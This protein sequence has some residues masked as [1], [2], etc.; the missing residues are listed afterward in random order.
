MRGIVVA[1]I[2]KVKASFVNCASKVVNARWSASAMD[3]FRVVSR[4]KQLPLGGTLIGCAKRLRAL[5]Y[6]YFLVNYW[7]RPKPSN[8]S[9]VQCQIWRDA[10]AQRSTLKADF[11]WGVTDTSATKAPLTAQYQA[12]VTMVRAQLRADT[13]AMDIGAFDGNWTKELVAARQIIAVDC[14]P[15]AEV[16]VRQRLQTV[17]FQGE[18]HF[19][20]TAGDEL[21]GIA[22]ASVDVVVSIDSLVRLEKPKFRRFLQ[23]IHRVLRPQG[24]A[25]I[26]VGSMRST[27]SLLKNF[28]CYWDAELRRYTA[29]FQST[30]IHRHLLPHGVILECVK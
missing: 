25:L 3:T 14:F 1:S 5:R 11:L 7:L 10:L 26:H 18:Y 28:V 19:Y 6:G 27:D 21:R 4:L 17:G 15:E 23:E 12:L 13:V 24:R 16:K 8:R 2:C 9:A 29:A 30:Q 20:H 22:D